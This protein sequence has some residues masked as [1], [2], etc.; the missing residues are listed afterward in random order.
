MLK[1]DDFDKNANNH[2]DIQGNSL[3]IIFF[4]HSHSRNLAYDKGIRDF[5]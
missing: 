3:E 5:K 4:N 2:G 1:E